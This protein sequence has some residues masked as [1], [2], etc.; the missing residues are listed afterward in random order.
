MTK[1]KLLY[2]TSSSYSGSTLL[3]FLLNTHPDIC[4]V[5]EMIGWNFAPDEDF[6]C[7][8]GEPIASCPLFSRIGTAFK[9]AGLPYAP[10]NFGT[11]FRLHDNER[12]NRLLA[13]SLPV[14]TLSAFER[15][16]DALLRHTPVF[17]AKLAQEYR[18]NR[19]FVETA[20]Q[21]SGATA[22]VDASKNPYRL[23]FL[24]RM[25]EFD[26]R[27]VHLV[28]DIRGQSLSNMKKKG[29]SARDAARSWIRDQHGISRI[30][31]EFQSHHTV[32][33]EDMCR[34][35]NN[36]LAAI[37]QLL[38]L[39]PMPYPG[40][41][42]GK[43]HHILGNAMR[44]REITDIVEDR[45]WEKGLSASDQ[46]IIRDEAESYLRDNPNGY[47]ADCIRHYLD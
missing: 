41:F 31:R 47:G 19:L 43:E 9:N 20:L 30:L 16:R 34:E 22:F 8:C 17:S 39:E 44:T 2:I 24:A 10:N 46:R 7:S 6:R 12:V 40:N 5:S 11:A 45:K 25:Q 42:K 3:A 29:W 28:R 32:Y 13:E 37:H 23:R 33:Y 15:P 38:G 27:I 14:D 4:T 21:Y 1:T 18:A 35:T 36:T 26:L